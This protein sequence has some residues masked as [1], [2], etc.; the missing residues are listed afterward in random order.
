MHQVD[1]VHYV[2]IHPGSAFARLVWHGERYTHVSS[3]KPSDSFP[4]LPA[5]MIGGSPISHGVFYDDSYDRTLFAPGSRCEGQPGTETLFAEN[6]DYDLAKLDGG[7]AAGSNHID[8]TICRCVLSVGTACRSI[9]TT[10]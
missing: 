5:F 3:S 2:A 6:L 10:S 7:G 4:G 1:L 9:R 8:P